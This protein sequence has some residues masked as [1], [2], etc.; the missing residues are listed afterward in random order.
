MFGLAAGLGTGISLLLALVFAKYSGIM[1]KTERSF[2]WI[3]AGAM[4]FILGGV[5]F[6]L[7]QGGSFW[8]VIEASEVGTG[9]LLLFQ[10]IGVIL[11]I[12]GTL[13]ALIDLITK[14]M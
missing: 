13:W 7:N 12:V 14:S 5:L 4:S 11:V 3:G 8:S 10:I 2:T 1:E 6:S 9:G